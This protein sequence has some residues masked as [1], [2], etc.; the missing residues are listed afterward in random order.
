MS[1]YTFDLEFQ[2][3]TEQEMPAWRYSALLR[4]TRHHNI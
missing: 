4:S 3:S 2:D 1:K